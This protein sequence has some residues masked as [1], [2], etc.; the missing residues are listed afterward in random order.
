MLI[1]SLNERSGQMERSD[2]EWISKN[3]WIA[4]FDMIFA[5]ADAINLP[6]TYPDA[7]KRSDTECGQC[8]LVGKIW[9]RKYPMLN[10][11]IPVGQRLL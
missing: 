9:I 5:S 11:P 1:W 3:Q 7:E 10:T 4:R 2:L 6:C 8:I